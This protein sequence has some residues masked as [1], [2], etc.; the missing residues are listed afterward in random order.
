MCKLHNYCSYKQTQQE[1]IQRC[2]ELS[3]SLQLEN[4]VQRVIHVEETLQRHT[5]LF[6]YFNNLLA[7][8]SKN[9]LVS[10]NQISEL[11]IQN[12]QTQSQ[13][14]AKERRPNLQGVTRVAYLSP[15]TKSLYN[16]SIRLRR[17]IRSKTSYKRE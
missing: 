16:I 15:R 3:H 8:N 10:Q 11:N 6:M 7:H 14:K 1:N 13:N 17:K 12:L 5:N 4:A 9:Q 2:N